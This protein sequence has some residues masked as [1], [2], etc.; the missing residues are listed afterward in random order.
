MEPDEIASGS[1]D[2]ILYPG[3]SKKEV[4]YQKMKKRD[5]DIASQVFLGNKGRKIFEKAQVR[6]S[7][8]VPASSANNELNRLSKSQKMFI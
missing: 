2:D 8:I 4:R 1:D 5:Q 3:M 7:H 6:N